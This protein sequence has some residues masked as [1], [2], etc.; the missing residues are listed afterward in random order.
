[1]AK[2]N[3]KKTRLKVVALEDR[4]PKVMQL[5]ELTRE[6]LL[7]LDAEMRGAQDRA[8]MHISALNSYIKQIDPSGRMQQLQTEVIALKKVYEDKAK[9][10]A[11]LCEDVGKKFS[12]KMQEYAFDDVT[13]IL[14]PL[15]PPTQAEV[16]S[17]Q[18]S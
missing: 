18:V 14:T 6:K 12:I 13:G 3:E 5:D 7:R 10:Y 8:T 16:K 15:P 2:K 11:E 4:H 1:M 9:S 17:P